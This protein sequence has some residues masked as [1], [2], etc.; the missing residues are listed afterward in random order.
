MYKKFVAILLLLS[1]LLCG[2]GSAG[3]EAST[4]LAAVYRVN[5]KQG[6]GLVREYISTQSSEA[7]LEEMVNALN[8]KSVNSEHTGPLPESVSII[9]YELSDGVLDIEM[10]WKYLLVSDMEKLIAQSAIVLTLSAIDEVC[11]I[12]ISCSGTSLA[13]GLTVEMIAESDGVCREYYRTL[14]LF[15]PNEDG[16]SIS[17]KSIVK[18]DNGRESLQE[19]MLR[20]IFAY[21]G[22]G[23]EETE[24]LS[25][26]TID[27]HCI[28]DLSQEFYGA[29]DVNYPGDMVIYSIVN[30]LC[31]IPG[32][33]KVTLTV[34]EMAVES[35]GEFKTIWPL[36]PN[37][38]FVSYGGTT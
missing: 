20:E 28:I 21:V 36:A 29:S 30:S 38:S 15:L 32:V 2:C 33:D 35:Y 37:T 1:L 3:K 14:K 34:E 4:N 31:R 11:Q 24:I 25:I 8:G 9:A 10:S 18:L 26:T 23:M 16:K 17:P 7:T 19:T 13:E 5:S 22:H 6:G 27:G 12:N